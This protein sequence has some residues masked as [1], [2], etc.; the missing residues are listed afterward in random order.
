[1][2]DLLKVGLDYLKISIDQVVKLYVAKWNSPYTT[3]KVN[4]LGKNFSIIETSHHKNHIGTSFPAGFSDSIIVCTDGGS[5][6]G[7]TKIYHQKNNNLKLIEDLDN[8]PA[9]GKFY[10]TLTQMIVDPDFEKAHHSYPGRTMGLAGLGSY[11]AEYS[12]L[13]K[14]NWK[15]LNKLNFNGVKKLN[16]LFG[17]SQN[18][19]N[20]W[21]D[22]KRR[23]LAYT[24]QKYWVDFFF[25]EIKSIQIYQKI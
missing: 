18:Y 7:S 20:Y 21:K 11:S 13:I 6:D 14:K 10:G 4:F 9:T 19:K 3:K 25:N 16:N 23:N 1:M 12:E 2:E 22:E 15:I 8:T 17:L 5:E 24:G